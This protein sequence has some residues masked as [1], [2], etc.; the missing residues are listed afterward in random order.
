MLKCTTT[1]AALNMKL[2][3]VNREFNDFR[4]KGNKSAARRLRKL[5]LELKGLAHVG[6]KEISEDLQAQEKVDG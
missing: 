4:D 5:L 1:V 2:A 3:E 6:R